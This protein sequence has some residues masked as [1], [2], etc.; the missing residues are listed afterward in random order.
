MA[1]PYKKLLDE[2]RIYFSKIE[3]P[4]IFFNITNTE[5]HRSFLLCLWLEFDSIKLC[6][7]FLKSELDFKKMK[8]HWSYI[9]IR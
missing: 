4:I 6:W 1:F 5:L 2:T 8:F 7:N 3:F 9:Q